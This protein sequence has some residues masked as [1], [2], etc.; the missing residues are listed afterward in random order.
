[1]KNRYGSQQGLSGGGTVPTGL[2]VHCVEVYG[3]ELVHG[4]S[5]R[6]RGAN[7]HKGQCLNVAEYNVRIVGGLRGWNVL[8]AVGFML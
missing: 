1:M 3:K 2:T 5:W 4:L 7:I 6:Q 8:A